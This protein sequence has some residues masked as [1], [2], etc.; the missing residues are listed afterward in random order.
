MKITLTVASLLDDLYADSA[1]RAF[2]SLS[3]LSSLSSQS[4]LALLTPDRRAAL[5]RFIVIAAAYVAGALARRLLSFEVPAP[6]GDSD[7]DIIL[8]EVDDSLSL[9]PEAMRHHLTSAM[10]FAV[11]RLVALSVGDYRRAE[12]FQTCQDKALEAFD[13]PPASLRLHP[14]I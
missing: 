14:A 11:L 4:P 9:V 7:D 8:F 10:T 3:S 12:G 5:R 13:P 2:S 6:D 1:L